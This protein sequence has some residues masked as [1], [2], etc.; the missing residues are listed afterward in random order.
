MTKRTHIILLILGILI[1]NGLIADYI[2]FKK[3]LSW[4]TQLNTDIPVDTPLSQLRP[5]LEIN[6]NE[7][8]IRN[9]NEFDNSQG[10][11]FVFFNQNRSILF[12]PIAEG[13]DYLFQS[14]VKV[15]LDEEERV[16][17]IRTFKY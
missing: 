16:K 8:G 10:H 5:Y 1:L 14:G 11:W 3:D 17:K 6:G 2:V 13:F 4:W 12:R 9:L 7:H 15:Q